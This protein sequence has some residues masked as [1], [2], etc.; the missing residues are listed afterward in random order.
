MKLNNICFAL[1]SLFLGF[2]FQ[3]HAQVFDRWKVQVSTDKGSVPARVGPSSD[4]FL[5]FQLETAKTY[6]HPDSRQL[7]KIEAEAGLQEKPGIIRMSFENAI[8][9]DCLPHDSASGIFLAVLAPHRAK[10]QMVAA[11]GT[12]TL[13]IDDVEFGQIKVEKQN[14]ILIENENYKSLVNQKNNAIVTELFKNAQQINI[15]NKSCEMSATLDL[16]NGALKVQGVYQ[17]SS[18]TSANGDVITRPQIQTSATLDLQR[19]KWKCDR[20]IPGEVEWILEFA[21]ST[22]ENEAKISNRERKVYFSVRNIKSQRSCG[23]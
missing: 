17:G 3:S 23:Q 18:F 20:S 15:Q 8:E 19:F 12:Y 2:G 13:I 10:A 16:D 11:P 21:D 14:V 9:Y 1:V 6:G 4:V 22:R 5:T 7:K